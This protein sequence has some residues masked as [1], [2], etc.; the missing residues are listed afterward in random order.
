M[1][2]NTTLFTTSVED[3][4]DQLHTLGVVRRIWRKEHTL[5]SDTPDEITNRLGWLTV[6]ETMLD[7]VEARCR[8]DLRR[9]R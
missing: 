5:W 9:L 1:L 3:R 6:A 2:E 8:E 7:E 4:L